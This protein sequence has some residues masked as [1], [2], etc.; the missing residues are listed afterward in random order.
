MA[1]C[2]LKMTVDL[3]QKAPT[4]FSER[5]KGMGH[6][7]GPIFEVCAGLQKYTLKSAIFI[8]LIFNAF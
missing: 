6:A 1:V 7:L 2:L 4:A 8:L 5:P 3:F